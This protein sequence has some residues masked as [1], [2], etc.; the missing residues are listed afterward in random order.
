MISRIIKKICIVTFIT[1]NFISCSKETNENTSNNNII[2][3]PKKYTVKETGSS[4]YSVNFEYNGNMITK[5]ITSFG[6]NVTINYNSNNQITNYINQTGSNIE[7]FNATYSNDLLTE[8]KNNTNTERTLYYYDS[9]KRVNKTD[10]F[11]NNFLQTTFYQYDTS[12]NVN[13]SNDLYSSFQYEYDSSSKPIQKCNTTNGRRN[14]LAMVWQFNKQ[15]NFS[16]RKT[17]FVD[18][19]FH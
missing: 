10:Y 11:E 3:K 2:I 1:V 4:A 17:K 16:K 7:T 12:G 15:S 6:R 8:L 14:F 5:I 19:L 9:N 18:N 13:Q